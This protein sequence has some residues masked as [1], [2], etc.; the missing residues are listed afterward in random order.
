MVCRNIPT[1]CRRS[2]EAIVQ[3]T[4]ITTRVFVNLPIWPEEHNVSV[5]YIY[6]LSALS[7]LVLHMYPTYCTMYK[8]NISKTFLLIFNFP[9]DIFLFL[10]G[11]II[12]QR[13]TFLLAEIGFLCE[14]KGGLLEKSI[15]LQAQQFFNGVLESQ[16]ESLKTERVW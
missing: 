11:T 15:C 7:T 9:R 8:E 1:F 6:Y 2:S 13:G 5:H 4:A 10:C 14:K 3:N 12:T 16:I